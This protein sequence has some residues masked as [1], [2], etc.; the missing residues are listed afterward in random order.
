[1][2]NN[3][4]LRFEAL[5]QSYDLYNSEQFSSIKPIKDLLESSSN[6]Y[7]LCHEGKNI[8]YSTYVEKDIIVE[9]EKKNGGE[10]HD[11]E[12]MLAPVNAKPDHQEYN[13]IDKTNS[14]QGDNE[15]D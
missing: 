1:M 8:D 11:V 10:K 13:T 3:Q 15:D 12:M 9:K 5:I 4:S 2:D 7:R 14:G 6:L